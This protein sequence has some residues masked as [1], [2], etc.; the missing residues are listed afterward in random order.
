MM[1]EGKQSAA[2][3]QSVI[4]T[5]LTSPMTDGQAIDPLAALNTV[6]GGVGLD[7]GDTGGRVEF[8]GRDPIV[9]SPLPLATLAGIAL[10]GKAAAVTGLWRA[11]GGSTKDLRL[12]QGKTPHRLCPF[13]DWKWELLNGFALGNLADPDSPLMPSNFY[14]TRDGRPMLLGN[15]TPGLRRTA[16]SF[17]NCGYDRTVIAGYVS[18]WDALALEAEA[19]RAGFQAKMVRTPVEVMHSE[20]FDH[21]ANTPLIRI[22]KLGDSELEPAVPSDGPLGGLRVLGLRHVIAGAGCGC[23]LA[24]HDADVL[25]SGGRANMRW[26]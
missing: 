3:T 4:E 11:R 26:N 6:L 10:M 14:V 1:M 23:A 25:T 2:A 16:L 20:Q 15:T 13:Y 19:E 21:V 5:A 9:S 7:V 8:V 24:Y 17:L 18:R 22:D 12:N